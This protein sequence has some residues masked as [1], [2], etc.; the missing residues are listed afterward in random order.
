M[1]QWARQHG[2]PWDETTCAFAARGGHLDV[3]RWAREQHCPWDERTIHEAASEEVR[4]WA[5]QHAA[6]RSRR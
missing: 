5:I 3:L 1:L 2:C 4:R 6:T